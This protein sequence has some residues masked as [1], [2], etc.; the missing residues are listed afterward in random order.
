MLCAVCQKETP[1]VHGVG[2]P[3]KY[4]STACR[5]RAYRERHGRL[6]GA[7][8][9]APTCGEGRDGGTGAGAVGPV[10]A[11]VFVS[12]VTTEGGEGNFDLGPVINVGDVLTGL[13][14]A[15]FREL[16]PSQK[17]SDSRPG[18]PDFRP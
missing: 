16:R 14:S 6:A 15:H 8:L 7:V 9:P 12:A 11:V 10:I 2:R 5:Q 1:E 3:R 17:R 4:C 13:T 18:E